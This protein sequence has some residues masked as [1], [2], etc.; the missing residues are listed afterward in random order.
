MNTS[1][2]R[3]YRC[4]NRLAAANQPKEDFP[5]H[6]QE[7]LYMSS[8]KMVR[9]TVLLTQAQYDGLAALAKADPVGVSSALLLRRFVSEGLARAKRQPKP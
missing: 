9:T 8:N 5:F 6:I 7:R 1:G 3:D 2:R 4:R